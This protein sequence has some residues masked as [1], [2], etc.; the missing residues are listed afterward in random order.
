MISNTI[1]LPMRNMFSL[2]KYS[3]MATDAQSAR[4]IGK[5][6]ALI[7]LLVNP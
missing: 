7:R 1:A 4:L 6:G 2:G 3:Q 5:I